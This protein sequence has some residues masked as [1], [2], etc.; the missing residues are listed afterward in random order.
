MFANT[1]F[2]PLLCFSFKNLFGN[3]FAIFVCQTNFLK[4]IIQ[5]FTKYM[6]LNVNDMHDLPYLKDWKIGMKKD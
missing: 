3:S 2:L 6:I 4:Y 1:L 5:K